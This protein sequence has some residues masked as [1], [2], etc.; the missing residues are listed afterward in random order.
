MS[1]TH[2]NILPPISPS[3]QSL[4]S[5]PDI[6]P[7]MLQILHNRGVVVSGDI[8]R[9]LCTDS[10]SEYDPFLLQDMEEAVNRAQ[11]AIEFNKK[12]AV[13]GDFDADGITATALL[14]EGLSALGANVI[15]Y[16]PNRLSDGYGLRIDAL[17][18]LH[19]QGVHLIITVD[20]GITAL[21]EVEYGRSI[22]IDFIITDHHIP[23]SILPKASAIINPKR[24]DSHYPFVD[25]AG[26]GV[27]CKF[28]QAL[29]QRCGAATDDD[30]FLD[31]VAIG[32]IADMMPLI[33]ENRYWVKRGLEII[34]NTKRPGL[35]EM[36]QCAGIKPGMVETSTISWSIGPRLNAAGRI[37][38]ATTSY[39]LL[40]TQDR[41]EAK[42]LAGDL[43]MKNADRLQMTLD[44]QKRAREKI[45]TEGTD[46]WL[47]MTGESDYPEGITGLV[48]GRL[49]DEFYR[50]VI[51][52]TVGQESTR[53]SGRSIREFNIMAALEQNADILIKFGGHKRAAGFTIATANLDMLKQ[54]LCDLAHK[55]LSNLDLRPHIDIDAE[56]PLSRCGGD[57][58]SQLQ[59]LAPFG[60]GNPVPVFVSRGVQVLEAK[61]VGSQENHLRL[62]V[63][64]NGVVWDVMGFGLGDQLKE[65]SG[66][67]DV[68]YSL[69]I[70]RW[71]G[72]EKLRLKLHDFSSVK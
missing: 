45:V 34:N 26:V 11:W 12:I 27:A 9:F 4:S 65:I 40:V 70:D 61:A 37:D 24:L 44:L 15:P 43:E 35:Q 42:Q 23:L 52:L 53:G 20:N 30:S 48:A 8:E 71:N 57:T 28:L 22:G 1:H 41:T 60:F 47:L 69:E 62:R 72:E 3:V 39:K 18:K 49:T 50:P 58:F 16:I 21:E 36:F 7:L 59:R 25:L 5:T 46:R 31:L 64:D 2:W 17:N 54:R 68:V 38:S 32:T 67:V 63:R 19:K 13:Y 33:G 14:V 56:I 51:L 55:E 10:R 29:R 6:S 66:H